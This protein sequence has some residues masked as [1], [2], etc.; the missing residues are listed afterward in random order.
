MGAVELSGE[1]VGVV[2]DALTALYVFVWDK[3][4]RNH[5]GKR[6]AHTTMSGMISNPKYK[7]YYVGN[8]VKSW[9]IPDMMVR[10]SSESSSKVLMLSFWKNT[11]TPAL[12]SSRV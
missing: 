2:A 4:Y 11:P 6:I 3:G 5:N 9:A 8:K 12:S 10:R 7:G 1:E